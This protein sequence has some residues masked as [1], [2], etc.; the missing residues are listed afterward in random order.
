M[1]IPESIPPADGAIPVSPALDDLIQQ[2]NASS[3]DGLRAPAEYEPVDQRTI[4]ITALAGLIAV[5][6]GLGAQVLLHLIGFVTNLAFY[7]RLSGAFVSPAGG[8]RTPAVLLLIPIVGGII[9]GFMAKYGSAA[10]RGHGIPE[11]MEK[12]LFGESKIPARVLILKPLSAAIAIGTGGPFGAE[13]PI[14]ATGGALGSL[15]GQITRVTADERKTLLGAGAAAGMAATFGTPVSAVLLAVELLLFEYRPR[16]LIPVALAAAIASG[17]RIAFNG[18]AP[19]FSIPPMNQPSGEALA[20]Y[21]VLG[22]VIGVIAAGITRFSYGIEEWFEHMGKRFGI[23]WMWW[24]AFGA[25]AVG[26]IGLIEPRT[27]GVG[28]ENIVGAIGGTIVG[29]ALMVLV[30]LKLLSWAI[31]LG[32]GTSGG[33]LAPLFTIGGGL[34][35]WIGAIVAAHAP[36]LGVDASVAGLVGMAAMFAGA[37]H[38]VL[39]SVV[40]AFETT[41]QPVGLLPLLVGC[42]A[43]FL[44]SLFLNRHSIMTEKLAR[45]GV[46]VRSEYSLDYLSRVR[47]GDAGAREVVTLRAD[48]TV[49]DAL[50]WLDTNVAAT[51]HQGFPIVDGDGLLVGVLTRRDIVAVRD[52]PQRRLHALIRRAPVVVFEHH[53]LRDAADQMVLEHVGRVP[54]VRRDD[55]RRMIGIL[56]RSDLLAAHAPRLKEAREFHRVRSIV[57]K[58]GMNER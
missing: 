50:A 24:P 28:Y 7:G 9:V 5:G 47:A 36:G 37:S 3:A 43:A 54:V 1:A 58:G 13:G 45:R 41:R 52:H 22:L 27:L 34:G 11:V 33:T 30:V 29:R 40:F 39:A 32:S 51:A 15:A 23:D 25:I 17:V 8:P 49:A 4:M 16:S 35:A 21:A 20:S 14:I 26:V 56:S 44:I 10:I 55:P 12:V 48:S 57:S 31:Y 6:A 19:V 2:A 42:T 38:A 53:T 46:S 18:T